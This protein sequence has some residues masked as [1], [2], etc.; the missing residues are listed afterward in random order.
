M[1]RYGHAKAEYQGIVVHFSQQNAETTDFPDGHFDLIVSSF[2]FHEVP[3]PATKRILK[4]CHRLLS[5]GGYMVHMELPPSKL[6]TPL[7]DFMWDWDTKNNNEPSYSAFRAPGPDANLR[8][9][10]FQGRQHDR[11]HRAELVEQYKP[12][13]IAKLYRGE[14]EVPRHGR[15]GWFVFGA[16][17]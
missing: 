8:R 14:G 3:V 5:K 10:R 1:L 12:E 13:Q 17:K 11:A 4:E 6:A 15:G 9:G 16:R 7:L 2:F